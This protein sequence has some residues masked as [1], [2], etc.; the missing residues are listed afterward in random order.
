MST[1]RRGNKNTVPSFHNLH[2]QLT[3]ILAILAVPNVAFSQD[4]GFGRRQVK[5]M[6]SDRPDMKNVIGRAHPIYKWVADGF[7]GKYLGQRVYWNANSPRAGRA[8]EHAVPYSTYPPY[9]SISGGTETTPVDKWGA[10]VF[11]LCNLQNHEQFTRLAT[12]ARAGKF[13]ADE[14]ATQCVMLEYDA[15]L[16]THKLFTANPLP[17]SHHSRDWWYNTWVKTELLSA[18]EFKA[19]YAV[20]GSTRSNFD[21]FKNA[22]TTQIAPYIRPSK[23]DEPGDEPKSR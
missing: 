20:P 21:Y 16:R 5:Q 2:L 23:N 13:T 11:E 3:A 7:H 18:K 15:Q 8:A 14:Y 4:N 1:V 17:D 6:L 22:Y 19:K 10:V 9:I 12:D